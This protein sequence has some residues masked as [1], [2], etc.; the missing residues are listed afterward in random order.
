MKEADG[1]IGPILLVSCDDESF[2]LVT[3]KWDRKKKMP[4]TSSSSNECGNLWFHDFRFMNFLWLAKRRIC[5]AAPLCNIFEWF[6]EALS[7]LK[8][9]TQRITNENAKGLYVCLR[10]GEG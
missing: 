5:I 9:F 3:H 2:V 6:I 1:D 4:R 8:S 7:F 10:R